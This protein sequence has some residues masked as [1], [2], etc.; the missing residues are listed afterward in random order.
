MPAA[1]YM[2]VSWKL[3]VLVILAVLFVV[4]H[5]PSSRVQHVGSSG[6]R[7]PISA[8]RSRL[9]SRCPAERSP[10]LAERSPAP[11]APS[12]RVAPRA[13]PEPQ[14]LLSLLPSRDEFM[15]TQLGAL[16]D[17]LF[18][19]IRAPLSARQQRQM[20]VAVWRAQRLL[21]ASTKTVDLW[22]NW[23]SPNQGSRSAL[24]STSTASGPTA[25]AAKPAVF[26]LTNASSCGVYTSVDELRRVYGTRQRWY[27]DLDWVGTRHLYHSLLPTE[28]I[29]DEALPLA[30]R[31]R[32][33]VSA[34][35]A[36]R[37]YARERALLPLCVGSGLLDGLRQLREHGTFQPQGMSEEQIFSKYAERAGLAPP[38]WEKG[39]GGDVGVDDERYTELYLTVLQKSCSTNA[40]IDKITDALAG[41]VAQSSVE[42]VR[43]VGDTL[44][45]MCHGLVG[46]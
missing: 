16:P 23:A 46:N 7:I 9:A 36:A 27:G 32:M 13:T 5:D 11:P 4:P 45:D 44:A 19:A 18:D 34:R 29:N 3:P 41:D 21:H 25:D 22:T 2:R 10:G 39:E 17:A 24:P 28:L 6:F 1:P 30:Q 40:R 37:L 43:S 20:R 15:H 31:A 33:A 8:L 26:P 35:R 38:A 12:F 14:L 42:I